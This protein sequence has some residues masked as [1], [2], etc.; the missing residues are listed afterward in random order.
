MVK[1]ISF[2]LKRE[3]LIL[4]FIIL[5][6]SFLR[7]PGVLTNSFAFTYDVGRD[8]LSLWNILYMHKLSLIGPT[9]GLPGVFYGP[10]WYL[11]LLPFYLIFSGNPQWLTFIIA[12][13]GIL[14]ICLAFLFGR[15]LGGVLLGLSFA[16]LISVSSAFTSLSSQIW[17]PNIAPIFVF[18]VLLILYQVYSEKNPKLKHF[19][20]LG[21][22][23][24]IISDL[25]IVFGLLFLIGILLSIITI[26]NKK[27]SL[28]S[29]VLFF[30]G[31]LV[32]FAPRI[33]FELRH[34]FLMTKSFVYFLTTGVSSQAPNVFGL[35]VNRLSIMFDQFNSTI[36]LDNKFLGLMILLFITF[37]IIA[38]FR[39]ANEINKK[40]I[41]TSLLVIL[42]FLIGMI[43]FKHDIWP[44]YLVG[45]PVFYLL[46]FSMAIN[47]IAQK[48]KYI[49]PGLTVI[50]MFLIN[51]NPAYQINNLS[52]PLWVGNASVYRNQLE[53]VDYVYR[54]AG[55]KDFKY[56]VYTP[57]VHD[58]TYQYLFKWY[59]PNEYHYLPSSNSRLAYF[60][61]EP[62]LQY[63]SRLS[64]WLKLR[65]K[66]G[67]VIKTGTF[68]SGIVVQTRIH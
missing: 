32:I 39:K 41:I 19:F 4:Y 25:E 37:S 55:G 59:G 51:L 24:A 57:P 52:K 60:I 28:K 61:L 14:T 3:Y 63:P 44:H 66:D 7:F 34:E 56:V 15:R 20:L 49:F 23:L 54:Q 11:I 5:V 13:F 42:I 16:A 30:L 62:D 43:F 65:E 47:I 46:F 9:T 1:K 40:F 67:I 29:I 50:V 64:D 10:S 18:F 31:V 33:L 21:F 17:S 53:I 8:L 26:L 36:A 2:L 6:G 12:L 45:L 22:I 27:L 48:T 58:Y 35:F 38:F 68:K